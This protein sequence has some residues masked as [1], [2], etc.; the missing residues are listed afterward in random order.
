MINRPVLLANGLSV[1]PVADSILHVR[2]GVCKFLLSN[3]VERVNFLVVGVW[4][5]IVNLLDIQ[6]RLSKLINCHK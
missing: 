3:L 6:R 2:V 4:K 5:Y 1:Q